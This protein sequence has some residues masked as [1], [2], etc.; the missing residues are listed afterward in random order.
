M[1]T[2]EHKSLAVGDVV[3]RVNSTEEMTVIASSSSCPVAQ[4]TK[5][6]ENP[7]EWKLIKRGKCEAPS[8]TAQKKTGQ[9]G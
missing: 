6:V 5:V 8:C 1:T 9:V 4:V 3:C 7:A 2:E